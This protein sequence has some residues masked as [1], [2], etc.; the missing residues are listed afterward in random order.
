M[1]EDNKSPLCILNAR[2]HKTLV[3]NSLDGRQD[4]KS[5]PHI[6][7]MDVLHSKRMKE[8]NNWTSRFIK[9]T[10]IQMMLASVLTLFFVLSLHG[11]LRLLSF[12]IAYNASDAPFAGAWFNFG[13]ITYLIGVLAIGM[14]AMIYR[15]FE[16]TL[17]I[18]YDRAT[19]VL[20]VLN[21]I[22]MNAGILIATWPMMIA[23]YIGGVSEISSQF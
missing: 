1:I 10:I 7:N 21:F 9:A 16:H 3:Q 4:D 12:L 18:A 19:S 8:R 11:P 20:A 5:I 13:Y 2:Q 23:G 14:T 15:Y 6:Y 17:C 22:L